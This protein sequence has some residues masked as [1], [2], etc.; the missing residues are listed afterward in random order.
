MSKPAT[1]VETSGQSGS[2]STLETDG[3]S[4]STADPREFKVGYT[5]HRK[6]AYRV[7]MRL[8]SDE[9][10][11]VLVEGRR[12]DGGWPT[13][14]V[15]QIRW[16]EARV[17]GGQHIPAGERYPS[18][19]EWGAMGWT[20]RNKQDAVKKLMSLARMRKAKT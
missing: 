11:V 4:A 13:Y 19:E 9:R 3:L 8:P 7:L 5:W 14:E 17:M 2:S 15:A 12:D 20:Y 18:A 10:G 1:C 6:L 16:A